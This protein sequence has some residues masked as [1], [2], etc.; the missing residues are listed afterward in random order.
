[1]MAKTG[2]LDLATNRGERRDAVKLVLEAQSLSFISRLVSS[3]WVLSF[4]CRV[5]LAGLLS[6]STR[7]ASALNLD[8]DDL[9]LCWTTMCFISGTAWLL[10]C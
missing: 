1:M 7:S 8:L 9:E 2:G 6:P 4:K 5:S 10:R 3:L